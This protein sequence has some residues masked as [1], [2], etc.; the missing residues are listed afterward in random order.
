MANPSNIH[1]S[2]GDIV[3]AEIGFPQGRSTGTVHALFSQ[4]PPA[5]PWPDVTLANGRT[6]GMAYW[7]RTREQTVCI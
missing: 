6:S 5:K 1:Y 3:H 4:F 2:D 7:W